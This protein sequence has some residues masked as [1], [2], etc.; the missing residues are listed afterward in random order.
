MCWLRGPRPQGPAARCR[1][2]VLFQESPGLGDHQELLPGLGRKSW[3]PG[4]LERRDEASVR[5]QV[6]RGV[7]LAASACP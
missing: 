7:P 4:P 5:E 2:K 3:Q 6:V 1:A